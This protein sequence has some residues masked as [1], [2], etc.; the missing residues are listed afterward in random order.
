[1]EKKWTPEQ[2][3]A[4]NLHNRSILVSAAAGSG[5][6]A[7]LIER[8]IRMMLDP[9]HP[10]SVDRILVVTFTRAAA[11]QMRDRLREGVQKMLQEDPGNLRLKDQMVLISCADITT[12]DSF[13]KKV[14]S[15]H[16]QSIPNLDP[17]FRLADENE[18]RL[19]EADVLTELMREKYETA[20]PV[21]TELV[22]CYHSAKDQSVL[23]EMIKKLS[24]TADNTPRPEEWLRRIAE[25]GPALENLLGSVIPVYLEQ[26][27]GSL[28]DLAED[29]RSLTAYAESVGLSEGFCNVLKQDIEPIERFAE[30]CRK[31]REELALRLNGACSGSESGSDAE[32]ERESDAE[33]E[34]ESDAGSDEEFAERINLLI[35]A[36]SSY[37]FA[38]FRGKGK[39]SDEDKTNPEKE[40]VT[41]RRD[42]LKEAFYRTVKMEKTRAND[43]FDMNYL[44]EEYERQTPLRSQ[45]AALALEYRERVRS[46]KDRKNLYGFSDIAHFALEILTRPDPESEYGAVPSPVAESYRSMYEEIMIDEYQDSNMIQELLLS[47]VSGES[48][49]KPNLFMVGDVKQSIYRFRNADPGIF[50]GKYH[51]FDVEESDHQKIELRANFRSHPD[52]LSAINY[53]FYRLMRNEVGGVD[54]TPEIEL[55]PGLP[56]SDYAESEVPRTQLMLMDTSD[57]AGKKAASD[58][59]EAE[60]PSFED[61][62]QEQEKS[63]LEARMIAEKIL[64]LTDPKSP[65]RISGEKDQ[66]RAVRY[67]DILILMRSVASRGE[68]FSRILLQYGIPCVSESDKTFLESFEISLL[69]DTLRIIDNPRQDIPLADVMLSPMFGFT[70]E[71][72]ALIRLN[73]RTE[74]G[75]RTFYD[76]LLM[77]TSNDEGSTGTAEKNSAGADNHTKND[78]EGLKK[79]TA[80]F[81]ETLSH[82]RTLST[83]LPIHDLLSR[84]LRER[85]LDAF[86][87]AMPGGSFRMKNVRFLLDQ[88]LKFQGTSYSGLFSFIRYVELI[89]DNNMTFASSE[90]STGEGEAVRIMTIHKSKGLEYPVVF[91]ADSDHGFHSMTGLGKEAVLADPGSGIYLKDQNRRIHTRYPGYAR[92]IREEAEKREALGEEIRLLYVAMTRAKEYLFL[93]AACDK[94]SDRLEDHLARV[95]GYP[96]FVSRIVGTRPTYLDWLLDAGLPQR[97]LYQ[98]VK[99]IYPELPEPIFTEEEEDGRECHMVVTVMKKNGLTLSA[100]DLK[101]M[102]K[103][104]SSSGAEGRRYD[105]ALDAEEENDPEVARLRESEEYKEAAERIREYY[106]FIYPYEAERNQRANLS[107]SVLKHDAIHRLREES[108]EGE[109]ETFVFETEREEAE[110][111]VPEFLLVDPS[112]KV[113]KKVKASAA[114]PEG[115]EVS[116]KDDKTAGDLSGKAD[117]AKEAAAKQKEQAGKR[118]YLSASGAERG[119]AFHHVLERL[120]LDAAGKKGGLTKELDRLVSEGLLTEREV[121]LVKEKSIRE[122]LKSPLGKRMARSSARGELFKEEPFFLGLTMEDYLHDI[123]LGPGEYWKED[124]LKIR[125]D[126]NYIMVQ[127]E[128][129]AYFLEEDRVILMDY[130]TDRVSPE[131][132][133]EVL[134]ERY[135]AQLFYYSLALSRMLNRP[136]S[137][138]WIYSFSLGKAIRVDRDNIKSF[139]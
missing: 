105:P 7:V 122:F 34:H 44:I 14:V 57:A 53:V 125:E 12:I 61:P 68:I 42:K 70:N 9:V 121:A 10:V 28:P 63:E 101:A 117:K 6:T 33:A 97:E 93:T 134:K 54:Y 133:E 50:L 104:Q 127:G 118:V 25:P 135:E 89:R 123:T 108:E 87:S 56:L 99:T 2:E 77:F 120:D 26:V 48:I 102:Q 139:I 92:K 74:A 113:R 46:V 137:E 82:Y 31:I 13:C 80:L 91:V 1:M 129:D 58:D 4:I 119:T 66:R 116:A 8:I 59:P 67:S 3:N 132:G 109:E 71:E 124:L 39:V 21:F 111:P 106:G 73:T 110:L 19:L 24:D 86:I 100:E 15:E 85:S 98:T 128:I 62:F 95:P 47:A 103:E 30:R 65:Y 38:A 94:L 55:K 23:P 114:K 16:Y 36:M 60:D 52:V 81:L 29:L 90:M 37:E 49:G 83:F 64:E 27:T 88:T 96:L 131:D 79:K 32:A 112:G 22:L 45:L 76:R 11:A 130:K 5:K 72:M 84:I 75:K 17:G 20:D 107:V 138:C 40:T 35:R 136:V 51:D 18:I 115:E 126:Q 43:L 69:L 41:S 78:I